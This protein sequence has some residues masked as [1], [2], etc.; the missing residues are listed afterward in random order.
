MKIRWKYMLVMITIIMTKKVEIGKIKAW[1][2]FFTWNGTTTMPVVRLRALRR[3]FVNICR[4]LLCQ[5][6][7]ICQHLLSIH[8]LPLKGPLPEDI[9]VWREEAGLCESLGRVE[10]IRSRVAQINLLLRQGLHC[11]MSFAKSVQ[12][13]KNLQSRFTHHRCLPGLHVF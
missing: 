11:I 2:W 9:L 3:S 12:N 4:Y 13:M 7:Y 1:W 6:I 5:Y 10:E 8:W